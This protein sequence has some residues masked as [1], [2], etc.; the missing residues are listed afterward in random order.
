MGVHLDVI[1]LAVQVPSWDHRSY[2]RLL[3]A[4]PGGADIAWVVGFVAAAGAVSGWAK[5][6]SAQQELPVTASP[7]GAAPIEVS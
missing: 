2:T 6:A 4:P 7:L 1:A 5:R 3:V